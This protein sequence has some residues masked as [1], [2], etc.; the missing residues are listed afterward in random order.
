MVSPPATRWSACA[1]AERAT[2]GED[3]RHED[4]EDRAK[5]RDDDAL[6]VDAVDTAHLEDVG[7]QPAAHETADDAEADHHQEAFL[8][9]HDSACNEAGDGADDDPGDETHGVSSFP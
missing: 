2:T 8:G 9:V 6:D 1:R 5:R 3:V 4:D 7:C